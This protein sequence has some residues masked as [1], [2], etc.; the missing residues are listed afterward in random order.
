MVA[1]H[2]K[3]PGY[4]TTSM[5]WIGSGTYCR[6]K[7]AVRAWRAIHCQSGNLPRL[8]RIRCSRAIEKAIGQLVPF[9]ITYYRP[10]HVAEFCADPF[11]VQ[12]ILGW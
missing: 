9:Q 4:V 7:G 12:R 6:A 2:K 1:L 3:V 11:N 10:M 5:C 8:Q